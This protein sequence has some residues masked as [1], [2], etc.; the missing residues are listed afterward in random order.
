MNDNLGIPA[1]WRI[2]EL[3][4]RPDYFEV[5]NRIRDK[6]PVYDA[7]EGVFLITEWELVNGALRNP[8]LR[9]GSGISAAFGQ[10]SP[11]ESVIRN[12]LMS[13]N[14]EEHRQA[15]GLVARVFAPRSVAEMEP[16]IRATARRLIGP[17]VK[18]ASSGGAD[19]VQAVA[20]KLPSE[21]VRSLF[22]I[23]AAEWAAHVEPL[24]L[25][26]EVHLQDGFAAVFGLT[27]YFQDKIRKSRG[28][29]IGGIVDL[30]NAEDKQGDCLTEAEVI[31]NSVLIVTAAVDTTAGLIANTLFE[32]ME[33]TETQARV[34]VDSSL[35]P[36]TVDES[37][38]H[39]PSAPSSTRRTTIPIEIG[40]TAIPADSDLFF[41]FAA[42][43]RDP[44]KFADPDRFDID[45][46]ASAL[47][48]FGGGA[49]FCLGAGLARMEARIVFEELFAAARDFKLAE[50][51]RW[52][53]NNPVV[54]APE[55]LMVSCGSA[56]IGAK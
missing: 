46:D 24:F 19:F 17:F 50:P 10:E 21:V 53:I 6:A 20:T 33:Q 52:R 3:G 14:G 11:V 40:G 48:T 13:L 39:C 29:K 28:E 45:R 15:R 36:A 27:P 16:V 25:G 35:I 4:A 1:G 54:R 9:A 49:H 55:K 8:A 44:K 26:P 7:G 34:Q 18:E 2:L 31:A 42:A 30:L 56:K 12:W 47:L 43:N 41:S 23:D 32:L 38:R 22:A 37:L 51:V 5:W